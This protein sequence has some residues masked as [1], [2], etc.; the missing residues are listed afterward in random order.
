MLGTPS[1][2]ALVSSGDEWKGHR[3]QRGGHCQRQRR[4]AGIGVGGG[5]KENG[6]ELMM[7]ENSFES[8]TCGAV[9][10]GHHK[11]NRKEGPGSGRGQCLA[12]L[13]TME[14]RQVEGESASESV[15]GAY[16]GAHG[17]YPIHS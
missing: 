15:W 8:R 2:P 7:P 5:G 17:R 3:V 16:E 9:W 12:E 4:V 13:R 11:D 1:Q 14:R 10:V 6:Q